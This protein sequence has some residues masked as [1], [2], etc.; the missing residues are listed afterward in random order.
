MSSTPQKTEVKKKKTVRFENIDTTI[1]DETENEPKKD[2]HSPQEIITVPSSVVQSRIRSTTNSSSPRT[3][4]RTNIV[5]LLDRIRLRRQSEI[6]SAA[7]QP[8]V[9]KRNSPRL[10]SPL[11]L[12]SERIP[13]MKEARTDAQKLRIFD[14]ILAQPALVEH[15]DQILAAADSSPRM[16]RL[17]RPIGSTATPRVL[18]DLQSIAN[19][20]AGKGGQ[21]ESVLSRSNRHRSRSRQKIPRM[22]VERTTEDLISDISLR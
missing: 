15:I 22:K 12:A 8:I 17:S 11:R 19:S 6:S 20:R 18:Q 21:P 3:E 5:E 10:P 9:P 7:G 2:E 4:Q 14:A 16:Q 13:K 1:E